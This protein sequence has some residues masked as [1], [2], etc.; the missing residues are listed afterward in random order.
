MNRKQMDAFEKCIER[1][2]AG[3]PVEDCLK[4]FPDLTP[5]LR[6]I[7]EIAKEMMS[8]MVDKVSDEQM[9]RSRTML[10][11]QAKLLTSSDKQSALESGIGK[12]FRPFRQITQG[13]SSL[14]QLAGRLVLVLGITGLLILLSGRILITSAKSI[15]GDSLYPVK[16][17]VED[18]R[19]YLAPRAVEQTVE[20]N[21]GLQRVEEVKKLIELKRIE[22][23]SFEGI[24]ESMSD[25]EWKVGGVPIIVNPKTT[26]VGGFTGAQS[27]EPGVL[28]EVEGITTENGWVT[29]NEIHLREYQY[30]G[31]VEVINVKFWQISTVK[32]LLTSLTQIDSGIHL[33]DDVTVLIRSEDSGLYALAILRNIHPTATPNMPKSLADTPTP[34]EDHT[35]V[36][37]EEHQIIGNLENISGNYWVV[38]G[39][40]IY[41]VGD[42]HLSDNIKIGDALA[43]IYKEEANGSFT[44]I[45]V[46]KIEN[47]QTPEPEMQ[48]APG[49]G[50]EEDNHET[51]VVVTS[52]SEEKDESTQTPEHH[53]TPQPTEDHLDSP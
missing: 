40:I 14:S 8:L 38:S 16:R 49:A 3:L 9:T 22:Q 17:A 36:I 33:G 41:V 39:Q 11:S 21:Y 23:I 53:E 19:V 47:D 48:Q 1:M 32:L 51:A 28:V 43:V 29:A 12:V 20:N 27:I 7:L 30:T 46:E 13:F 25:T 15:P 18:I 37:D 42:T 45:D 44:A 6:N 5:E 24:I 35:P 52:T 10:L 2:D 34:S 31:V 26:I 4:E 50:T